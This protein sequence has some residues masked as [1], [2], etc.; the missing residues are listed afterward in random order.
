MDGGLGSAMYVCMYEIH[1]IYIYISSKTETPNREKRGGKETGY[2][3]RCW[4][5]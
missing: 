3:S 2:C 4:S 1:I 5:S